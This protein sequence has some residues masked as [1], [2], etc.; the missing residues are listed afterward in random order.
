MIIKI[1]KLFT[2][3]TFVAITGFISHLLITILG[4][5]L[6]FILNFLETITNLIQNYISDFIYCMQI[7]N[8]YSTLIIGL[9]FTVTILCINFKDVMPRKENKLFWTYNFLVRI[10]L[11]YLNYFVYVCKYINAVIY[12]EA[13]LS[14]VLITENKI[15]K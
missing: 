1:S 6:R 14:S 3:L 9:F 4:Y 13:K 11:F 10:L 5:F 15:E 12:G 2:A 7:I 8:Y